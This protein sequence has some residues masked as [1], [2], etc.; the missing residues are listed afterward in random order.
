MAQIV[1]IDEILKPTPKYPIQN[2]LVDTNIII[3]YENPF[4]WI[5]ASLNV[6]IVQYLNQLKSHYSVNSTLV[7]ALE[8]FKYI[9]HGYYNIF[10]KTHNG[11]F[12]KYTTRE[13]KKLR[14]HNKEFADGW[15]LHLKAFKRTFRKHFPPFDISDIKIYVEDVIENFDGTKVD[16]GDEILYQYASTLKFPFIITM[17]R[18]FT[19]YPDKLNILL[20]S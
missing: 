20:I 12:E 10:V 18:D 19:N 17:D 4:G 1:A 16:F 5:H 7:T 2:I 15:D 13:F 8:Y 3:N 11:Y 14:L 6:K 9:Q